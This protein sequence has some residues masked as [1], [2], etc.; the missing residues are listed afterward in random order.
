MSNNKDIYKELFD[1]SA[2][3]IFIVQDGKIKEYNNK[4]AEIFSSELENEF[5]DRDIKDFFSSQSYEMIQKNI[6]SNIEYRSF[7]V[8][9]K[10]KEKLF[11]GELLLN[12]INCLN[13][14]YILGNIYNIRD[15]EEINVDRSDKFI[16]AI[17][18]ES[19]IGISVRDRNGTLIFYNKAWVN[20]WG[21]SKEKLKYYLKPKD[22]LKLNSKDSYLR[23]HI[24]EI[25][26][27][28]YEGGSYIVPDLKIENTKKNE[29]E[30]LT[31]SFYAIRDAGKVSNVVILTVDITE[32]R[33]AE[34]ELIENKKK[35]QAEH[36]RLEVTLESIAEGVI[37]TDNEGNINSINKKAQ[38][39]TGW[40]LDKA[41]GEPLYK[42]FN[43]KRISEKNNDF[44]YIKIS[45][46]IDKN[47][48]NIN[49][50]ILESKKGK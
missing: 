35:L 4:F 18:E 37:T 44:D 50:Y 6:N 43:V 32:R 8:F 5:F 22:S 1:S 42:I 2:I 12:N 33:K 39:L 11:K 28:Y 47:I 38:Q 14:D 19:P 26:K 15:I 9:L 29:A 45:S 20:I 13:E 49:H 24:N 41:K 21:I 36:E 31:Q 27:I 34:I 46:G 10:N 25:K 48:E 16:R 7:K 17:L 30:W 23:E 40:S 3:A